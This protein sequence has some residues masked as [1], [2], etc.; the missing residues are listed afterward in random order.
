MNTTFT[1]AVVDDTEWYIANLRK[2]VELAGFVVL[3]IHVEWKTSLDELVQK[4][5]GCQ[6][7]LLDHMMGD[8]DGEDVAKRLPKE[9]IVITTSDH[10][11]ADEY[12]EYRLTGKGWEKPPFERMA[13]Q[14]RLIAEGRCGVSPI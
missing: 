5:N 12:C 4:L 11:R 8:F 9:V 13:K 1:V 7:V 14:I 2:A 6:M 10:R 3:P